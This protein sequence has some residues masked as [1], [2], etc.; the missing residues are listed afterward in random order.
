MPGSISGQVTANGTGQNGVTVQA[1][2]GGTPAR[3]N[4]NNQ[5]NYTITNLNAGTYVVSVVPGAGQYNPPTQSVTLTSNKNA[6][7]INFA[8]VMTK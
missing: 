5:G 8:K 7:G 6:M 3:A 1:A 2:S 4:T